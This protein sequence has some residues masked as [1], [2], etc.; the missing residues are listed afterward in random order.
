MYAC[1]LSDKNS[2]YK[3]LNNLHEESDNILQK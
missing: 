2:G 1:F 3:Y